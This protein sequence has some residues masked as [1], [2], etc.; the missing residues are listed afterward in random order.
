M[1]KYTEDTE[2]LTAEKDKLKAEYEKVKDELWSKLQSSEKEV[3]L[4]MILTKTAIFLLN[5]Q[6]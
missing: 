3:S 6:L 2:H 4:N 5:K 1:K